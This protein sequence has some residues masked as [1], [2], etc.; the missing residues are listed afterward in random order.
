MFPLNSGIKQSPFANLLPIL[1]KTFAEQPSATYIAGG[2]LSWSVPNSAGLPTTPL[3]EA[4]CAALPKATPAV[5]GPMFL[6][7]PTSVAYLI[8]GG[9]RQLVTSAQV[10]SL[11]GTNP[12]VLI[13]ATQAVIDALPITP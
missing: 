12:R 9:T 2:G 5:T 1:L 7:S 13:P 6:A 10:G 3:D 11:N 4:T 8:T